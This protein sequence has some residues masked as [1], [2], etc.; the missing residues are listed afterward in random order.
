[1]VRPFTMQCP[2]CKSENTRM[3]VS[4]IR[5][6]VKTDK[7]IDKLRKEF[8]KAMHKRCEED[9]KKANKKEKSKK[10]C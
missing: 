2:R 6:W 8:E 4:V 7:A 9:E 3:V 10:R 1:M 5:S